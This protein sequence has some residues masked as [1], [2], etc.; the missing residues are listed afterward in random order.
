MSPSSSA[1]PSMLIYLFRRDLRIADNP[2]LHEIS[3]LCGQ[4][5]NNSHTQ[6][7]ASNESDPL[8]S[9][10]VAVT[11]Q[12]T[13]PITHVL[14]IYVFSAQQVEV[15]GFLTPNVTRS[16]YPQARSQV[17]RYWRCGHHRAKFLAES[18]WDLK[19]GLRDRSSDLIIR[20]GMVADVT[21]ALIK[22]LKERGTE[23]SAIWMTAEEGVEEKRE[24]R[25]IRGIAEDEGQKFKLWADEKYF[26]DEYDM[27][28]EVWFQ[29]GN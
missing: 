26:V 16:P 9:G 3:K 4:W 24:E 27:K 6:T 11:A 1:A 12:S 7:L 17:G 15:S 25:E 23:V 8:K 18:V 22:E 20:V 19:E 28:S 2:V 13:K 5:Q 14:P 21:K 29:H 10:G